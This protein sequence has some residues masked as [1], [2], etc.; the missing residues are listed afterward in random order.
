M[1]ATNARGMADPPAHAYVEIGRIL[2]INGHE[3]EIIKSLADCI[4]TMVYYRAPRMSGINI[5]PLSPPEII[6][7]WGAHG[8]DVIQAVFEPVQPHR[9][10]I[11][12][13]FGPRHAAGGVRATVPVDRR[14]TA[15]MERYLADPRP[16][17][18][19]TDGVAIE[20][21]AARVGVLHGVVDMTITTLDESILT[22]EMGWPHRTHIRRGPG[23]EAFWN[24]WYPRESEVQETRTLEPDGTMTVSVSQSISVTAVARR[25]GPLRRTLP[26]PPRPPPPVRVVATPG[27]EP[28]EGSGSTHAKG[29]VPEPPRTFADVTHDPPPPEASGIEVSLSGLY[30]CRFGS[31]RIVTVPNP[32]PGNETDLIDAGFDIPGGR[33]ELIRWDPG[34]DV[35]PNLVIRTPSPR[36]WPDIRILHGDQSVSLWMRPGLDGTVVGGLPR[37]YEAAFQ[38]PGGVR[39]AL[40][41]VGRPATEILIPIAWTAPGS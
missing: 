2:E 18:V 29:R 10:E 37:M 38:N 33:V 6:G 22:L 36:W 12:L 25:G 8:G 14:R 24:E 7:G 26:D 9:D 39:I 13:R 5:T 15:R 23:P 28:L 21:T 3:I 11:E 30:L 40:R 20:A 31:D 32:T 27:G 17:V 34:Y 1:P 16:P 4:G 41:M 19:E 35:I